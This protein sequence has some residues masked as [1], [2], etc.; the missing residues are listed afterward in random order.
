[1]LR[2]L[3]RPLSECFTRILLLIMNIWHRIFFITVR[4]LVHYVNVNILQY[5]D[6]ERV[7]FLMN[8]CVSINKIYGVKR[9]RFFFSSICFPFRARWPSLHST[10]SSRSPTGVLCKHFFL[11]LTFHLYISTHLKWFYW[12]PLMVAQWYKILRY[13]SEGRLFDSRWCHWNFSLT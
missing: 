2:F 7:E 11:S 10:Q 1:M 12:G 3:L 8:V 9:K 4:L 6:M 13:E 5:T